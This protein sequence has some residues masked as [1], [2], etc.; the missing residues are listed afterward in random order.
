[1]SKF[2]LWARA[3]VETV[4]HMIAHEAIR[5]FRPFPKIILIPL[6]AGGLDA[7]LH[8]KRP[9]RAKSFAA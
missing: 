6:L 4:A 1:M 9:R 8:F 3:G 2:L 5:A 7:R